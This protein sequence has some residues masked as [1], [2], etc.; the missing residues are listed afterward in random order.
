MNLLPRADKPPFTLCFHCWPSCGSQSYKDVVCSLWILIMFISS[1][2]LFKMLQKEKRSQLCH[3]WTDIRY[4]WNTA[5]SEHSQW[6]LAWGEEAEIPILVLS[7][8]NIFYPFFSASQNFV[9]VQL[10]EQGAIF[11]DPVDTIRTLRGSCGGCCWQMFACSL[12]RALPT[13]LLF[14]YH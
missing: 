13:W 9:S 10:R 14:T 7:G 1:I 3:L 12:L 5:C 4:L 8:I 11:M 6:G 2:F